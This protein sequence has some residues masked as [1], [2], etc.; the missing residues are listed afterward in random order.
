MGLLALEE[1]TGESFKE[2]INKGLE[3]VY[4]TNELC[5]DMRDL[6]HNLIWRCILP[7]RGQVKYWEIARNLLRPPKEKPPAGSLQILFE[8]RPYELGWLLYAFAKRRTKK[9]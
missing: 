4:G 5:T 7:K 1:A 8:D 3:W 2:C 9:V 6:S